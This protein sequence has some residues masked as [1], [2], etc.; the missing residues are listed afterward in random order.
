[1]AQVFAMTHVLYHTIHQAIYVN[2]AQ[3]MIALLA[4]AP[5]Y[6]QNAA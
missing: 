5:Q 2:P 4:A 1:M 3:A 6:A